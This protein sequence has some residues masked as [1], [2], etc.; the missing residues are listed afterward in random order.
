MKVSFYNIGCKVNFAETS[1]L[2]EQFETLGYTVVEFGEIADVVLINTCTVTNRADADCRKI[3]RRARRISPDAFIGIVGC[4]AQLK[5]GE[6]AEIEGVDAVLGTREK[7]RITDIID[8]FEK[9]EKPGI[10]VS[11]LEEL[12]FDPATSRDNESHT[13]V[14]LKIQ[15]GCDYVC[16]YCTVPLARGA[17]RSMDFKAI[18]DEIRRIEEAGFYEIVLSGINLGEYKA[19]TGENFTDL[20]KA[21]EVI[22]TKLRFRISSIEPNLLFPEI[23]ETVSVSGN[24]CPHFHIPLQSGSTEILKKMK[25]RYKAED[26]HKL[27]FDIKEKI[28]HCCIGVDVIAGFP[29][30]N[31]GFFEET[32]KLI[33]SLPVS[34]LHAFT[35][36]ERDNTEALKLPGKVPHD[37][38]KARTKLL[39]QLSDK[40]QLHFYK[41]HL[42]T[43]HEVIPE[44]FSEADG[45][46]IGWT[47][48]YIKTKF[49]AGKSIGNVPVEVNL[50]ELSG[51]L[52]TGVLINK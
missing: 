52:I 31:E 9:K 26:F 32:Y 41:S 50:K 51:G 30:E 38:R 25:R 46:W 2:R 37:V 12:P 29:G 13:R 45:S 40:K 5:P 49:F 15:D 3:I 48:N 16:T 22:D 34:Y 24:F 6:I 43:V 21:I 44:V 42:N 47:E 39:R 35:Y 7:F 20:V 10:Y 27:V 17:C 33:D 1:T 28:P 19:P 18:P 11:G 36:S 4:Y 14:V 8:N 23:L